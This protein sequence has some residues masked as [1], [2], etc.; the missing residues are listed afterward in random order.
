MWLI[1]RNDILLCIKES[2][3]QEIVKGI[4]DQKE[5]SYSGLSA[6]EFTDASNLKQ[7]GVIVF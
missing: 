7:P 3:Q 6:D 5:G 1:Y 4:E 2:I